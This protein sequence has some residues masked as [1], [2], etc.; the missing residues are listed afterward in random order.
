MLRSNASTQTPL[1]HSRPPL[2]T[3]PLSALTTCSALAIAEIRRAEERLLEMFGAK[4]GESITKK[5]DALGRTD[6]EKGDDDDGRKPRLL[7][8]L[9]P[10][11]LLDLHMLQKGGGWVVD[12]P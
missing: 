8:E 10:I 5:S 3:D 1:V 9:L 2:N 11:H 4:K 7:R 6:A 12:E